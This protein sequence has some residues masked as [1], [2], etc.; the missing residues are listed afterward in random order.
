MRRQ[1]PNLLFYLTT[2]GTLRN[3]IPNPPILYNYPFSFR[4][5]RIKNVKITNET[6]N[7][8]QAYDVLSTS[9]DKTASM[10]YASIALTN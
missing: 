2:H 6:G 7:L 9:K 8:I 1:E 10:K 3:S 4:K 5:R